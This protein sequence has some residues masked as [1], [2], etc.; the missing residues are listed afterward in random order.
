MMINPAMLAEMAAMRAK[1][2]QLSATHECDWDDEDD[3]DEVSFKPRRRSS[4]VSLGRVAENV[5]VEAPPSAKKRRKS[6]VGGR[7]TPGKSAAVDEDDEDD[8]VV[9]K[10]SAKPRARRRGA[11]ASR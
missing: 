4:R 5:A 6:S 10:S 3:E 1:G 8:A 11:R 2:M 9:F 7:A